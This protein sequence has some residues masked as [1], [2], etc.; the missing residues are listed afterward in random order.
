MP[1]IASSLEHART[2]NGCGF[3][4][5]RGPQ[6]RQPQV[7]EL[8]FVLVILGGPRLDH[9]VFGFDE[10]LVRFR[11]LDAVALVVVDVVRSAAAKSH[12]QPAL[13]DVVDQRHLLGHADR[14]VQR[15]LRDREADLD[16]FRARR[17]RRGESHRVDVRADAVE[18]VLGQPQHFHAELVAQLRLAQGLL[19]Y[20]VVFLRVHRRGKQEIAELHRCAFLVDARR[21]RAADWK[22]AG[23]TAGLPEHF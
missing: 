3:V 20:L 6:E 18:M 12:H 4:Y 9:D 13:A 2:M 8:A 19:D 1:S 15:H 5:G 11:R 23:E 21:M 10:T 17:E 7:P 22:N 14:M 16:L